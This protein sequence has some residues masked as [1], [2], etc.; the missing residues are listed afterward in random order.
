MKCFNAYLIGTISLLA[1]SFPAFSVGVNI[2]VCKIDKHLAKVGDQS[3]TPI[4]DVDLRP[5]I[6]ISSHAYC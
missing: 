1:F 5:Y 2:I 3:G 6:L 4:V